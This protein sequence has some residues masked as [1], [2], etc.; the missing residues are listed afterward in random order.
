MIWV[1]KE[2]CILVERIFDVVIPCGARSPV[3]DIWHRLRTPVDLL[4]NLVTICV[5]LLL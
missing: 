1:V 4:E 5:P 3:L 2:V